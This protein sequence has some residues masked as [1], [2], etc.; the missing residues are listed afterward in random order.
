MIFFGLENLQGVDR[1]EPFFH[2]SLGLLDLSLVLGD[3]GKLIHDKIKSLSGGRG[4]A[5][6]M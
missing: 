1:S 5:V 3:G 2:S 6:A 4:P